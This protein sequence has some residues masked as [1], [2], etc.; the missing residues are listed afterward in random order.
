MNEIIF[1]KSGTYDVDNLKNILDNYVSSY[2]LN[3]K[4][5]KYI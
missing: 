2:T 1:I 4:Y 3:K 5:K